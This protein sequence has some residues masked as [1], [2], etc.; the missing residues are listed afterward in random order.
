MRKLFNLIKTSYLTKASKDDE[1]FQTTQANYLGKTKNIVLVIPYGLYSN[2]KAQ[3]I[4]LQ[5]SV[6]GEEEKQFTIPF[7]PY[8]RFKDLK[9]GEVAVGNPHVSTKIYFKENGDIEIES[10]GNVNINGSSEPLV[11]GAAMTTL[12]NSHTHPSNGSPP[13]QQMTSTEVSTKNFTE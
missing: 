5:F 4:G 7:N 10:S 2:P 12:F 6:N 8:T 9:G 11:R 3:S 13:T 1:N